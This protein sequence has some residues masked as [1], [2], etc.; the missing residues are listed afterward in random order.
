M[1]TI[2]NEEM[3]KKEKIILQSIEHQNRIEYIIVIVNILTMLI[4][5]LSYYYNKSLY[6]FLLLLWFT[7]FGW[8]CGRLSK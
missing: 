1:K 7:S 8:L 6:N 3:M 4:M 5:I 2:S